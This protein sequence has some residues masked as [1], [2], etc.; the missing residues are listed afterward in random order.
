MLCHFKAQKCLSVNRNK[1]I[2]STFVMVAN[3]SCH[4]N[5]VTAVGGHIIKLSATG[6]TGLQSRKCFQ[7]LFGVNKLAF[8]VLTLFEQI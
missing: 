1:K 3:T 8:N 5:L 2:I 4:V 6:R 7:Q